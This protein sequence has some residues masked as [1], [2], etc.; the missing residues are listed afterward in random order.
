MNAYKSFPKNITVLEPLYP[1][2]QNI[3]DLKF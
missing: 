2:K 1:M 3:H